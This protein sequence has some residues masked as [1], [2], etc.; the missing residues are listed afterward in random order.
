M[1]T[2][3]RDHIYADAGAPE[4]DAFRFDA[5]VA[6]VFQDMIERSV[7][8]YAAILEGTQA[9]ARRYA[10]PGST[11]YDL[12]CSLGASTLAMLAGARDSG[13]LR[14]LAIDASPPMLERCRDNVARAFPHAN[15]EYV[16]ADIRDVAFEHASLVCM[17]FTLQFLPVRDRAPLFTRLQRALSPAGALILSEK[18]CSADEREA[19]DFQRAHETFKLQRGYSQLEVARKRAALEHVLLPETLSVHEARLRACGFSRLRLWFRCFQFCS[20]LVTR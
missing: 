4:P 15:V 13:S 12:G 18:L 9:W 19:E 1:T 5:R 14:V 7:P 10:V 16:C 20:L 3:R 6:S 17:N 8:G 11:C 2:S